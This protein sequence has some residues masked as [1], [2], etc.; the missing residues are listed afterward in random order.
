MKRLL[1]VGSLLLLGSEVSAGT[2]SPFQLDQVGIEQKLDQ[3]IPLDVR[4]R[5]EAGRELPLASYFGQQPVILVPGRRWVSGAL[6][7][8][9]GRAG[10]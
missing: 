5:D 4:L 6:Q 8:D 7:P 2:G 1:A 3:T 9:P 10:R